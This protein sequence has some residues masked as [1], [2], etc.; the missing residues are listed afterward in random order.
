MSLFDLIDPI[1]PINPIDP[2][3]PI[4]PPYESLVYPRNNY[5]KIL[6]YP[7]I[8]PTSLMLHTTVYP[9]IH[10]DETSTFNAI[11]RPLS[12]STLS[13]GTPQLRPSTTAEEVPPTPFVFLYYL[14]ILY[15]L[16]HP[17]PRHSARLLTHPSAFLTDAEL[18]SLS[19]QFPHFSHFL[20][21]YSC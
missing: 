7:M 2:I 12:H 13:T 21:C 17:P 15:S 20:H 8:P 4:L 5:S 11:Y 3:D 18:F 9:H 1:D 10:F 6:S 14:F 16:F 19:H